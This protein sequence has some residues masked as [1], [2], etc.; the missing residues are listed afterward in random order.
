MHE[1][2][3][4]QSVVSAVRERLGDERVEAITLE[5]G[6]LSGVV[7]DSI[8]FCFEMCAEGTPLAGA[9]LD[10]VDVPGRARCRSCGTTFEMP[11]P[12]PLC[13][14]GSTDLEILC[15]RELRI[16]HVTVA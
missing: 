13:G 12:L 16:K 3:I 9:A 11:D 7:P 10:I 1:L 6:R 2:S 8:R 4:T 14:C 5:I 15:G